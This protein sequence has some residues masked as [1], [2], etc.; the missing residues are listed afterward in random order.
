MA[1]QNNEADHY[2][3]TLSFLSTINSS[4]KPGYIHA[5]LNHSLYCYASSIYIRID[6]PGMYT[7]F[8]NQVQTFMV[9]Q[10]LAV[11]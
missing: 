8:A 5:M 4:I 3:L 7:L 1:S 2:L 11:V 10:R 6:H 9:R